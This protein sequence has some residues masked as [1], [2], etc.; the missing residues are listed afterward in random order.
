MKLRNGLW[1]LCVSVASTVS[2][3]ADQPRAVT[4]LPDN[5]IH[6]KNAILAFTA[7][8]DKATSGAVKFEP[9]TGGALLPAKTMLSGISDGVGQMGFHTTGLTPSDLPVVNL[10]PAMGY[11]QPDPYVLGAAHADWL[12]HEAMAKA[13][14]GKAGV[15]AVGG[16]SLPNLV[17]LCVGDAPKT[18]AD[19]S[20]KR[21]RLLA[22]GIAGEIADVLGFTPVGMPA[23]EIYLALE[24]GQIDCAGVLGTFI[25]VDQPLHEVTKSVLLINLPPTFTDPMH[26]YNVDF[27]RGLTDEQRRAIFDTTARTMAEMA[28]EFETTVQGSYDFAR[29]K[30]MEMAAPEQEV[31]DAIAAWSATL[32]EKVT[33]AAV[34]LKLEGSDQLTATYETYIRKWE[35][36]IAGLEDRS[37]PDALAALYKEHIFDTLDAATYG[38]N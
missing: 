17:F 11:L 8:L 31:V 3:Q 28:V 36:L 2:A 15:V 16:N 24:N 26:I 30:G 10:L 19:L 7:A 29:N 1:A 38:M 14:F 12:M 13:E 34:D 32:P 23:T 21:I 5:N 20:G 33:Q 35:S 6:T 22:G 4:Y 27:W 9:H 25:N 18:L 37:N